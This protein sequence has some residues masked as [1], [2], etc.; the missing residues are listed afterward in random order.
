MTTLAPA[1]YYRDF[2][3]LG[4]P[5]AGGFV[6]T[7]AAGTTTPAATYTD[8]TG[9]TPNT[10]PIVLNARGEASIWIPNNTAYKFVVTDSLGNQI[11]TVDQVTN[12]SS[13]SNYG[14]S[15]TGAANAYIL[16]YTAN[17]TSYT[18]GLTVTFIPANTNTGASTIN[19]NSIGAVAIQN[20]D[21]SAL[22][23]GQIV[24]SQ[25]VTLVY[26]G[27]SFRLQLTGTNPLFLPF[28]TS[29]V[30]GTTI[31]DAGGT[32]Q[33]I[34]YRDIPM[35]VQNNTYST[36]LADAG[37]T[38][39]HTDGSAYTWT[40]A[41]GLGYAVG[42]VISFVNYA[43]AAVSINIAISGGTLV[44]SPSGGTGSRVLAQY[45]RASAQQIGSNIW[46]ISG[47]GLT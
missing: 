34:G 33:I 46:L 32:A 5:L 2:D 45:G 21:G 1:L 29:V 19:I 39:Y 36:V 22:Q 16:T 9:G 6:Y 3:S 27:T 18:N 14:G 7:Y 8:S 30:A 10:N 4:N 41:S 13:T 25:L 28:L 23:A 15:D 40:I 12:V 31:K 26:Q 17:F 43:S 20:P 35:N 24:A 37:K 11:R 44:W 42:S 38:I 47:T